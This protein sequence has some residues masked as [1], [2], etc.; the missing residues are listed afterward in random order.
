MF[1]LLV[2][3]FDILVWAQDFDLIAVDDKDLHR[4]P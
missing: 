2:L 3:A 1:R 4:P